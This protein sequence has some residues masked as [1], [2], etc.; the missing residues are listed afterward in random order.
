MSADEK[1]MTLRNRAQKLHEKHQEM[2]QEIKLC[3]ALYPVAGWHQ[4]IKMDYA[5]DDNLSNVS[6]QSSS[7]NLRLMGQLRSETIANLEEGKSSTADDTDQI[8]QAM[9]SVHGGETS[10]VASQMSKSP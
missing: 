5:S 7:Q 6:G 3:E 10:S 9:T 2:M 8:S 4:N 1:L